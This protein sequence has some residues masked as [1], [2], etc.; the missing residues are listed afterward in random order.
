[1]SEGIFS[2]GA[3]LASERK[4]LGFSQGAMAARAGKTA[5]TV[6]KYESEETRPD[7]AFLLF[8]DHLGADIYYIVTGCK[9]ANALSPDEENLLDGYRSLDV[10]G[11]AG[12]LA[13]VDGLDEKNNAPSVVFNGNVGQVVQG[14]QRMKGSTLAAVDG[15]KKNLES[16]KCGVSL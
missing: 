5:R 16:A 13:L 4:R 3:R 10:R 8:L 7:A 12:V 6:I 2:F 9:S 15:N 14:N 1:M 11:K